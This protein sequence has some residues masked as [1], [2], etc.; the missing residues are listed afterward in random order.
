MIILTGIKK[1]GNNDEYHHCNLLVK[2][3]LMV[4]KLLK[5]IFLSI[6]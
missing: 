5:S 1:I 6:G 2:A 4:V 3:V